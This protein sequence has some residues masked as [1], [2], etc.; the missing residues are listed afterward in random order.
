MLVALAANA[1]T[2]GSSAA[3]FTIELVHR[4]MRSNPVVLGGKFHFAP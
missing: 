1:Q 4:T 2:P 3:P